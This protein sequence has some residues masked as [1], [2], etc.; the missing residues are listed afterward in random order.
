MKTVLLVEDDYSV[1]EYLKQAIAWKENGYCVIGEADNGVEA[2]EVIREKLPDIMITDIQMPQMNG[3]ELIHRIKEEGYATKSVVL[4]FYDDF[5]YVRNAMKDGAVDYILKHQLSEKTIL[6]VL[7][8]IQKTQQNEN[9]NRVRKENSIMKRQLR[10]NQNAVKCGIFRKMMEGRT[11][12]SFL[13]QFGIVETDMTFSVAVLQLKNSE[14]TVF[15][16]KSDECDRDILGFSVCNIIEEILQEKGN[17]IV[18]TEDNQNYWIFFSCDGRGH[19]MFWEKKCSEALYTAMG[20]I[21][22]YL[23]LSSTVGLSKAYSTLENVK[24]AFSES[25]QALDN[26]YYEG[27]GNLYLYSAARFSEKLNIAYG[28]LQETFTL[29]GEQN[30]LKEPLENFLEHLGTEK[31]RP[32]LMRKLEDYIST[33]LLSFFNQLKT[34][35]DKEIEL[36]YNLYGNSLTYEECCRKLVSCAAFIDEM[37]R[38]VQD[39][40]ERQEINDAVRYI[41]HN[42]NRNITLEEIAKSVNLSKV[43]FSQLFKNETGMN[44]TDFLIQFRIEEAAKLLKST[45]MKVYEIAEQ[46]GIPDQHYFNRLFKNITGVTPKKF[47]E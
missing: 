30:I 21:E 36:P 27:Y 41:R 42:Y 19:E 1:R 20:K 44:F 18:C 11:E 45:D 14:N 22:E 32:D 47:R 38:K 3:T 8:G 24:Q 28:E 4:S 5:E 40:Y 16:E 37:Q 33:N 29:A 25:M 13:E 46:V 7:D 31:L 17:G 6:S 15:H 35:F 12:D 9:I 34:A 39:C 26:I 10:K 23:K 43:Y 2:L